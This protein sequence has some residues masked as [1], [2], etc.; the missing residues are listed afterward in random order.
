M[1]IVG[2]PFAWKKFQGGVDL[3]WV[4]FELCLKGSKLGLSLARSQ[5]LVKWLSDTA[6]LVECVL[7]ICLQYGAVFLLA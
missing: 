5:W 2:L 4:G 1:T 3:A 7:R 6:D